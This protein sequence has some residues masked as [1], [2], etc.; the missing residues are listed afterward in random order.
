M[1]QQEKEQPTK[2]DL[3]I[4]INPFRYLTS[5]IISDGKIIKSNSEELGLTEMW[6]TEQLNQN[7]I[8]NVSE[9]FYAELQE[10]G[11]L[12]IQKQAE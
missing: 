9:V 4:S 8:K 10:N 5:E 3:N 12:Y 1:K 2:N 6:L 11:T 7:K